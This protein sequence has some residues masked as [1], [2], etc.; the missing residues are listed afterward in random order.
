MIISVTYKLTVKWKEG[1]KMADKNDDLL[2]LTGTV[3]NIIY[4]NEVNYYT[5]LELETED[6]L[7]TV[8]GVF[9]FISKGEDLKVI[10]KWAHHQSFGMQF[11][12]SAFE[13]E[14][15]QTS[16]AMLKYL[17]SGV[18]K[19]VGVSIAKRIVEA[20]GE[21]TMEVIENDPVRLTQIKG[22][23]NKKALAISDEIKRIYGIR[24]LMLY[25]SEYGVTA[26]ESVKAWKI[27]GG[28]AIH[29]IKENPY[30][31][32][33]ELIG[34]DFGIADSIAMSMEKE[35]DN[36]LRIKAG[37]VYV[38]RH[39][40]RNGHSCIPS[41]KLVSTSSRMLNVSTENAEMAISLLCEERSL[42]CVLIN[43]EEFIFLKK[44]FKSELYIA[45]RIELMLK[46]PP[47]SIVGIDTEIEKIEK[48]GGISYAELQKTAIRAALDKGM[49]ILTGGPGTG[50]T[51]TLNA[52]INILK[53]SGEKVLLAAPT[54]RAAK[55]MSDLTGEE[56]KT[57]HRVLQVEWDKNDEPV[58]M[59]NENNPL[60][61]DVVVVDELSMVDIQ[62]MEGLLSAMPLGCRLILVGDTDQLPSVGAGNILGDL[63]TSEKIPT[64]ELKEIFRQAQQSLIVTNSHKIVKGEMPEIKSTNS[65]FFFM[66]FRSEENLV[67]T[68]G[69]LLETR[70][71]KSYG[72]EPNEDIQVLCPSRMGV[73]G[74]ENLNVILR[75]RINPESKSKAQ[76]EIMGKLF[77]MGD[78]V[79][80]IKNNYEIPW[81][82]D[83]GT[84]GEGVFNG[85]MGRILDIDKYAKTM[86]VRID[87]KTVSYEFE[88]VGTELELAYAV[89][90]HKSQG[91]EFK[92]VI[93]PL[94]KG[95]SKLKYRNLLYTAVTR[96]KEILI[97]A[98][99][100]E[101]IAEMVH[102]AKKN[103][104]YTGLSHMLRGDVVE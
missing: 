61:C 1:G 16:S 102:N 52:I 49:L 75:N 4:R 26:E 64:V 38:L 47:R 5:V 53:I 14:R 41:Q 54:G 27:Y 91:N 72:Y 76:A 83:D 56:A 69:D 17:S 71:P 82:K 62:V 77:R 86:K 74:T 10:G 36:I 67:K 68:V 81:Y 22:I 51:T 103:L 58:F 48:K 13:R 104:R 11:K 80:H 60:E 87:D 21:S 73:V 3:E 63:I 55:R 93:I 57:I 59:R 45:E 95:T 19:G 29:L 32:C 20:F 43:E 70:L 89:T 8:V 101:V 31:I 25:L 2:E 44:Y 85:D 23:T 40:S 66:P 28:D 100:S 92:A 99:E 97:I 42:I 33:D 84:Y 15:P 39:N 12:A 98:G 37:I 78:K 79:M 96:A 7:T 30:V 18:V 6:D 24:E 46:F 65:D 94:F 35:K 9:P 34:I 50:K 90:V 88:Q